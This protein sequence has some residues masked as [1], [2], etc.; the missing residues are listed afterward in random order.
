M[1]RSATSASASAEGE[2]A[3]GGASDLLEGAWPRGRATPITIPVSAYGPLGDHPVGGVVAGSPAAREPP[4]DRRGPPRS[5]SP[6]VYTHPSASRAKGIAPC[7]RSGTGEDASAGGP[8]APAARPAARASRR[9]CSKGPSTLRGGRSRIRRIR[10]DSWSA[11]TSTRADML[12]G[13]G[14]GLGLHRPAVGAERP[15]VGVERDAEERQDRQEEKGD[16]RAGCGA[17]SASLAEHVDDHLPAVGA[18]AVLPHVDALPG[19]QR[20]VA[21]RRPGPARTSSGAPPSRGPA[22]RRRPRLTW[23]KLG[24]PSGTSRGEEGLEVAAH[25]RVG[26]LLDDEAGRGVAEEHGAQALSHAGGVHRRADRLA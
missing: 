3:R 26:V 18:V 14:L 21:A 25:R 16:R 15:V 24:S 20:Q 1:P 9:A 5:S 7:C 11:T 8:G 4:R 2:V 13:E 6:G 23:V 22:C 12:G 19:A 10:R 17:S